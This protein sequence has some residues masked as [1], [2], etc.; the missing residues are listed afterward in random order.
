M[1]NMETQQITIWSNNVL[2]VCFLSNG[3]APN[4]VFSDFILKC[5]LGLQMLRCPWLTLYYLQLGGSGWEFNV[6]ILNL[7]LCLRINIVP[8]FIG[9]RNTLHP[10][11]G[12]TWKLSQETNVKPSNHLR[13]KLTMQYEYTLNIR[14][15]YTFF[16]KLRMFLFPC[17]LWCNGIELL[18][19]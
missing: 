11:F 6:H 19:L 15:E 1:L 9:A 2:I 7:N 4:A 12:W 17:Y 8:E 16:P 18:Q 14:C 5:V 10:I 13:L 3:Y